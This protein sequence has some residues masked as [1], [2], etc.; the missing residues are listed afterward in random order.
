MSCL[1]SSNITPDPKD[2]VDT[3]AFVLCPPDLFVSS[4]DKEELRALEPMIGLA[5]EKVTRQWLAY[6]AELRHN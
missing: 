3:L 5:K 6:Q 1:Y 2:L 4:G